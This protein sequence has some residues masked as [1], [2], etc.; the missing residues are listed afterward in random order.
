MAQH[1]AADMVRHSI[2]IPRIALERQTDGST[3]AGRSKS[4]TEKGASC[5]MFAAAI[6]SQFDSHTPSMPHRFT[7]T[8]PAFLYNAGRQE[9]AATHC[10]QG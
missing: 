3:M 4:P 6:F 10:D 1:C 2:A 9:A 7:V 5:M 8:A